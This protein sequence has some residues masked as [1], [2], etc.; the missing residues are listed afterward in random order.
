MD[1]EYN[2]VTWIERKIKASGDSGRIMIPKKYIG[3]NAT[4]I[5][6][7]EKPWAKKYDESIHEKLERVQ[8]SADK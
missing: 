7:R 3:L 4:V 6:K 1:Q 5:I 8:Q 2:I